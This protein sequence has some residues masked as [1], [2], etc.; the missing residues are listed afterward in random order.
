MPG[1]VLPVEMPNRFVTTTPVG[2]SQIMVSEY[3]IESYYYGLL[4]ATPHVFLDSLP[5]GF[6]KILS[7]DSGYFPEL[8]KAYPSSPVN[9]NISFPVLPN[10]SIIP[11]YGLLGRIAVNV[12]TLV[13]NVNQWIY[14][15]TF[16]LTIEYSVSLYFETNMIK[17]YSYRPLVKSVSILDSTIGTVNPYYLSQLGINLF[18]NFNMEN[19]G[20]YFFPQF[21]LPYPS[22]SVFNNLRIRPQAGYIVVDYDVSIPDPVSGILNDDYC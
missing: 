22:N 12:Q 17:A 14:P 2:S 18:K 13:Y 4:Q 7:T 19:G 16:S 1:I 6:P 8:N 11:N 21:R 15:L 10:I 20:I 5:V 9:L 3:L